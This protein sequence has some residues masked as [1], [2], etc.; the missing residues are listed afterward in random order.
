MFSLLKHS[1][2]VVSLS[3]WIAT[4]LSAETHF[5]KEFRQSDGLGN[6]NIECLI[7][8][9]AGFL[10]IGTQNGLFR[11]DGRQFF[12]FG[13]K[14]G[15][16]SSYIHSLSESPDGTLWV[17]SAQGLAIRKGDRFQA[18]PNTVKANGFVYTKN[19][20]SATNDGRVYF[21]AG[22][23][24]MVGWK[25]I[26]STEWKF[27]SIQPPVAETNIL[28]VQSSGGAIW[29]GCGSGLCRIVGKNP[30]E[31][32]LQLVTNIPG[33]PSEQWHAMTAAKNGDLFLRSETQL[34]R[35][36]PAASRAENLTG[37]LPSTPNR[38]AHIAFDR[39][40]D[41]LATTE[42]GLAKLHK[43]T[44]EP[45]EDRSGLAS[46]GVTAILSDHEG[47]LWLGTMGSGL[48]RWLGYGEWTSWIKGQGLEDETVWA[49]TEDPKGVTWV[50]GDSGVFH[51]SGKSFLRI[52]LE[53]AS[54]NGLL[55]TSDG[56]IWAGNNKGN[57][58][59]TAN[60]GQ[61]VKQFRL[62]GV[63]NI[64]SLF[65]DGSNHIW[66]CATPGL[67]KSDRPYHEDGIQ[68][69]QVNV[70]SAARETFFQGI[71]DAEQRIWIAGSNGLLLKTKNGWRRWTK[72]E[73]LLESVTSSIAQGKDGSIWI[74]YRIPSLITH[75]IPNGTDWRV[76][77]IN[78]KDAPQYTQTVALT[79]DRKGWI[80]AGTDRGAYVFTGTAWK[81]ITTQDGL[82]HDDLNSRAMYVAQ[83]GAVWIGTSEGL[84]RYSNQET[85]PPASPL[86]AVI[87]TLTFGQTNYVP[88][89]GIAADTP[90]KVKHS[91]NSI[92]LV[93]SPLTYRAP[94][95]LRF[96][97]HL[98]GGNW[99][100]QKVDNWSES[101]SAEF[102]Y[103]NLPFGTYHLSVWLR[104]A[105][106]AWS[107]KP[108]EAKF[109]IETPWYASWWFC[110][111]LL[112]LSVGLTN[113]NGRWR[114]SKHRRDR[115]CLEAIIVERTSE[116]EAAKNRAEQA[117]N[118][119]SQFL[120]N[121]SHEIR[122]PMN[123]ILGMTQLALATNLD[124]RQE[125]YLKTARQSAESLLTLLS[126]ILDLSKIE[127]GQMDVDPRPFGI[128]ECVG[129]CLRCFE[130]ELAN[131]GVKFVLE[132]DPLLP[133]KLVGDSARLRQILMN[134][135]SNS[136]KFTH[137]GVVT[138]CAHQTEALAERALVE[139]KVKDTGIGISSEKRAE[140][141][142][143]FRQADG[144]NTRQY[145]GTGLGL[146]ISKRLVELLGGQLEVV[147]EPNQGSSFFFTLPLSWFNNDQEP[148]APIK[149][150]VYLL[151]PPLR[152]LL[153]EDNFVNQKIVQGLL[154]KSGHRVE[155]ASNGALAL[156][157]LRQDT[158][159]L[160]L[161]DVQMPE[162][163]GITATKLVRRQELASKRR[164]P[165][166][167]MTAN[168]M[169]GDREK[170]LEAGMD[171]YI[172]KPIRFDELIN[173]IARVSATKSTG[174]GC[175]ETTSF[176][177][178][179][180]R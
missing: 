141:F 162:M 151:G 1:A 42:T 50:G 110:G 157:R 2:L 129:D 139:F 29:A 180:E 45:I 83:S 126:D 35:L 44:W 106:G 63:K 98:T 61:S 117:N 179:N 14:D 89:E 132:I 38:R 34:W 69:Q 91:E 144:S 165:I 153:A 100:R 43:G 104:N 167:A 19:G 176:A 174:L 59:R 138:V 127:S 26:G 53:R 95:E 155:V 107:T 134:L 123:G 56:A 47:S 41:L 168:A 15:I 18:I 122:T 76:E 175:I 54:Y 79:S 36:A 131:K 25:P 12:E 103:P 77:H 130:L 136:V 37:D 9:H 51:Q 173:A 125:E 124:E 28:A 87:A 166:I 169:K 7:Q 52:P 140:I 137:D 78:D 102:Q 156:E 149:D 160:V 17:G 46:N 145:G 120:A 64:R 57:L 3:L 164:T 114:E 66:I 5:F 113:A 60:N 72:K 30:E 99:M 147:S 92:H 172:S 142:E 13:V 11:Y 74:A 4:R 65:I 96:R 170:C 22:T 49:I 115:E 39:H 163:D 111:S 32:T 33:L 67:W 158:F 105:E 161:M 171:H 23:R 128:R 94:T 27:R 150:K 143:P 16:P 24:L 112:L 6:L 109:E 118:L 108:I 20:I 82:A 58:F 152:I 90:I 8:D 31:Q 88:L 21:S 75:L 10:W 97:Y 73:G 40:G 62:N 80:W 133:S 101:S 55:A 135:I 81:H 116:L 85:A 119:K 84:S 148:A 71:V 68:F 177:I 86:Q 70:D 178:E 146:A 159:D 48:K 121:M 93:V 154:E